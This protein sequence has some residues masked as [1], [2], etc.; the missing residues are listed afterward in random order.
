MARW[1]FALLC[2]FVLVV[3]AAAT[4][5]GPAP[6][7]IDAR[8]SSIEF[9]A[10]QAGAKFDGRFAQWTGVIRFDAHDL[11][12]SSAVVRVLVASIDTRSTD[13]DT[14]LKSEAWFDPAR[15][16]QAV[17]ATTVMRASAGGFEADG[18]LTIRGRARPVKLAFQVQTLA[19]GTVRL[20]GTARLARLA[21]GLGQGEFESV[22]WVGNDVDVRVVVVARSP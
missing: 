11:A 17:F 12:H 22:E 1:S 3:P 9:S 21:F 20:T 19:G 13:R 16:P 10:E 2:G 15:W 6:W 18:M 5:A 7:R 8:Q 4:A 14:A